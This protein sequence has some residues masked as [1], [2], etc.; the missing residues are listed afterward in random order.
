MGVVIDTSALIAAER[1]AAADATS[2][3]SWTPLFNSVGDQPAALPAIVYAE[4]L[5]GAELASSP[6][7]AAAR[8]ARIDVLTAQVSIVEF[9]AEIAR[10]WALLFAQVNRV[11]RTLPANDLAVAATAWYLE[12][13]VLVAPD[14]EKHFRAI[15]GLKVETLRG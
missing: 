8:R 15:E 10:V 5:V 6:R 3:E 14:D 1:L 2:A 11:G 7:R 9:D 12:Y 4:L 13:S